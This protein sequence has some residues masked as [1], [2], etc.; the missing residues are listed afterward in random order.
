MPECCG[1]G[2]R[3]AVAWKLVKSFRK[4]CRDVALEEAHPPLP[5][6]ADPVHLLEL[7]NIQRPCSGISS[8]VAEDGLGNGVRVY[9]RGI[10][11]VCGVPDAGR[12]WGDLSAAWARGK[13]LLV[14][15]DPRRG[16]GSGFRAESR[17]GEPAFTD[18]QRGTRRAGYKLAPPGTAVAWHRLPGHRVPDRACWLLSGL[19]QR[20]GGAAAVPPVLIRAGR[21]LGFG[22]RAIFFRVVIPSAMPQ[23]RTGLRVALGMSFFVFGTRRTDRRS[24]RPRC[25]DYGRAAGRARGS[26]GF[27]HH[28]D[29]AG[30]VAMRRVAY[31]GAVGGLGEPEAAV[32]PFFCLFRNMEIL[33]QG[34]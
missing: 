23:V 18:Y 25:N 24:G 29:R 6:S 22:R 15:G 9:G 4:P 33:P 7:G 12:F 1:S 11:R 21:M 5:P 27:G 20:G 3:G 28:S 32:K 14:G 13:R 26:A 8:A 30:G 17:S 34:R 2:P 19:P 31:E 16:A 10:G